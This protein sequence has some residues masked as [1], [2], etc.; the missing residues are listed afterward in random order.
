VTA[1][2]AVIKRQET[3]AADLG[4]VGQVNSFVLQLLRMF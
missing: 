1:A 3:K 2:N 4:G